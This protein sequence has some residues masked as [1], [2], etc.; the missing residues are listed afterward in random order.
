MTIK[1]KTTTKQVEDAVAKGKETMEEAL[2]ASSE[3]YEQAVAMTK[4]QVEKASTAFFKG[5]DDFATI[6]KQ[7]VDAFM[8][9]GNIWAKGAESVSKAYFDFAQASAEAGVEATKALMGAKTVKEVVDLQS[10]YARNRFDNIV[11]EGTRISEMAVQ[12]SN[13]AFE[14]IQAQFTKTVE[15]ALKTQTF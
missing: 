10:D 1:A 5:Y 2:K 11:A 6:N 14:P 4:V 7:N 12:V 9:A 8:K 13:Q 3:G 15:K